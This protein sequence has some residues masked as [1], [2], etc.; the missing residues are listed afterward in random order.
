MNPSIV[1]PSSMANAYHPAFSVNNIKS[2][3]PILLNQD[4]D[5][6]Y[7]SWVELFRNHACAYD[8]LHH[9]D[10][11]IPPSVPLFDAP[12]WNRID[13]IVKQWIY[14]TISKYLL[15]SI[16]ENGGATAQELWTRLE[17]IFQDDQQ[18]DRRIRV[19]NVQE[20]FEIAR[21]GDFRNTFDY[22][23]HVRQVSD[24]LPNL[25]NPIPEQEIDLQ[26]ISGLRDSNKYNPITTSFNEAR[27]RLLLEETR[28]ERQD[29]PTSSGLLQRLENNNN[30]DDMY[31]TERTAPTYY[32]HAIFDSE[33]DSCGIMIVPP[34]SMANAYHPAFSVNNIKSFIPILLNQDQDGQYASWVELF[35]NH[36]CAYDVLHH[37]D[38]SIPPSVPLFDAPT[39]NRIDAIVKQWIY[40]TISKY[41]L[42]SIIENGGATAQELW[43]RLEDIFQDDQQTDR[44]IRVVNVQEQFEIARPGDFRNTFDYCRHVRQVS[45]QLPN[46]GN[47][48]PEQEIDLQLISGLR[49]SNK[50]NPITTSFN[51]ARDRL[52]L[53]ETR[54][55]RQDAPTSSGLL[56]RLEN[57]NN[58]DD[59]YRTERT[60][61]TYYTHAIFDSE[62]D[63]CGI[64]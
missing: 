21:P 53:E 24:Q 46:L 43:T 15:H 63:S 20:Q 16:I 19:V 58:D 22:C 51:E 45:D 61:P 50:Y 23:R 59:M 39:W 1:P 41:L 8:V 27:D 17:D 10:A 13:A 30:D 14:G 32:T 54:L 36:A 9:I 64:M 42:H 29:A 11:S 49:D 33:T 12:T 26:L 31:R 6:Q 7:A 34:S 57:N 18:T 25:G 47:P 4:Q 56:Q 38:A 28:L 2:F 37:I 3:I 44:R 40:G 60:A 52:L 48:I 62:T 35:R 5:G 55:E